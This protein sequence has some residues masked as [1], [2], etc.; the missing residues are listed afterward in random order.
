MDER[1][2]SFLGILADRGCG[3]LLPLHSGEGI[4]Q[5]WT[6]RKGTPIGC[7][8]PFLF[9]FNAGIP[10]VR[11]SFDL[12]HRLQVVWHCVCRELLI[13]NSCQ[14]TISLPYPLQVWAS[15]LKMKFCGHLKPVIWSS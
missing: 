5:I 3:K 9:V 11:V 4:K 1:Q 13:N 2:Q 7:L 8:T 14:P 6:W 15:T 12:L 10:S